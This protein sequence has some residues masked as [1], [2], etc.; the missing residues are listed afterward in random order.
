M[1]W[2]EL[3]YRWEIEGFDSNKNVESRQLLEKHKYERYQVWVQKVFERYL[4]CDGKCRKLKFYCIF[5]PVNIDLRYTL[6]WVWHV[7][8]NSK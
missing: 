4:S 1:N 8:T 5:D 3:I 6:I 2:I 7:I